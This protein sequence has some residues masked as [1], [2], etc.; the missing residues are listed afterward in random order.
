MLTLALVSLA[1]SVFFYVFVDA[2]LFGTIIP[3]NQA[4]AY[5]IPVSLTM[6]LLTFGITLAPLF[7]RSNFLQMIRE[8]YVGVILLIVIP[9]ILVSSGVLDLISASVIEYV[10][11]RWFLNWLNYQSWWWMDPYPF[12]EWS[13]P[14]SIAWLVSLISGHGHTLTVDMLIGSAVG[15]GLLLFLWTAYMRS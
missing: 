5:W 7:W 1:F 11:G 10:R 4:P 13:V 3:E 6:F 15:L 9:V 8:E 12:G 14:W 2:L